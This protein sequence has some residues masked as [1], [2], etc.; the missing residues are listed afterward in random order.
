MSI[1]HKI[2][3]RDIN[4]IIIQ[5][6]LPSVKEIKCNRQICIGHLNYYIY[7]IWYELTYLNVSKNNKCK[8]TKN[9][10]WTYY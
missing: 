10:S 6:L 5:Y 4:N 8:R 1:T 3:N 9:K 2:F 7:F